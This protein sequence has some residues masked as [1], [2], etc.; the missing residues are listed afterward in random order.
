MKATDRWFSPTKSLTRPNFRPCWNADPGSGVARVDVYGPAMGDGFATVTSGSA[1]AS[2]ETTA[3][4]GKQSVAIRTDHPVFAQFL[5]SG[6]L[7]VAVAERRASVEV[8]AAHLVKLR[9]FAELCA[10]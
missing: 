5:A 1:S 7:Q 2:A 4:G 9:R 3:G 10:G 8:Q 6:T